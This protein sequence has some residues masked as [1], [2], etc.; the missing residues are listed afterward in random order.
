MRRLRAPAVAAI[1][2]LITA[3]VLFAFDSVLNVG[4]A[5]SAPALTG[6]S[7]D[8]AETVLRFDAALAAGDSAAALALLAQDVVVLE[9]GGIETR[10][11]YRSQHLTADIAFAQAVPSQR[12]PVTVRVRGDVAW[13]SSTSTTQGEY[14]GRQINSAGAALIVLSRERDGWK[15][16]A[17]HW[18]SRPRRAP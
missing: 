6:D 7:S 8:V 4:S 12:R 16:R 14:R 3:G 18:S 13:A 17:I 2:I 9:S 5:S 1:S 10:D 11:E 15:I